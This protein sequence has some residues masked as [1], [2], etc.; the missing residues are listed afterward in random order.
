[1]FDGLVKIT[2]T[3][4]TRKLDFLQNLH[5]SKSYNSKSVNPN[6]SKLEI[7]FSQARQTE[8]I[9]HKAQRKTEFKESLNHEGHEAHEE[10]WL[11]LYFSVCYHL[12]QKI[13]QNIKIKGFIPRNLRDLHDLRGKKIKI[14]S[15]FR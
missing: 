6:S 2:M 8:W 12:L 3:D 4:A 7:Y 10:R 5:F 1:M 15:S 9:C 13:T 14:K 11:F